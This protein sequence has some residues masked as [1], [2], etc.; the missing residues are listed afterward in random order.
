MNIKPLTDFIDSRFEIRLRPSR[1]HNTCPRFGIAASYRFTDPFTA[2]RH[3]RAASGQVKKLIDHRISLSL[4]KKQLKR[5][6]RCRPT[7]RKEAD[8]NPLGSA[9]HQL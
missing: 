1:D 9:P 7:C 5:W 6:K 3:Q 2:T 8:P 4:A